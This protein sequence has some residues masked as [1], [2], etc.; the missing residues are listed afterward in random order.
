VAPQHLSQRSSLACKPGFSQASKVSSWHWDTTRLTID[1]VITCTPSERLASEIDSKVKD[2]V[3]GRS[4]EEAEAAL[5]ALQ[6]QGL[7]GSYTLPPD[8]DRFPSFDPLLQVEAT[9]PAQP[10]PETQ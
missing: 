9:Q 10:T 4:R 2:A 1:G 8:K 7:I 3:L 5:L 6:Q